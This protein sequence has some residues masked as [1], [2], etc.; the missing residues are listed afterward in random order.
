MTLLEMAELILKYLRVYRERTFHH[1][2][3]EEHEV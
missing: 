3:H 1:E 2:G